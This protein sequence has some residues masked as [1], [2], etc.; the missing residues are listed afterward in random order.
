ME[1][2]G[3][4]RAFIKQ[5]TLAGA[6]MA[7]GLKGYTL[8]PQRIQRE[9]PAGK[10]IG[11]IGLDT[12]HGPAFARLL[13][14]ADAPAELGGFKI[15][16]ATPRGSKDIRSSTDMIP[17]NTEA[18]KAQGVVIVDSIKELLPLVDLVMLETNDGRLHLEQ[19]L[20]VFR[21][22]KTMFIDKPI[23]ASLKDTL[24][25]YRA[26]EKYR[27]P[28][29]SS[30]TLR[31]IPSVQEVAAGKIGTVIGADVFSPTPVEPTHPD[32]FWYGVHGVEML[33]TMLG[34]GCREVT[35]TYT[36]LSDMVVGVWDDQQI[37]T[38]RGLRNNSWSFGGYAY[39]EKGQRAALGDFT[40][41]APLVPAII[42]FF[43]TGK[44][45]VPEEQTIGAIAFMEAAEISKQKNGASIRI[46]SVMEL[47]EKASRKQSV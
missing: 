8:T 33:Y 21:A 30:S 20:P 3:S 9:A 13:N 45:P 32:L 15:V 34:A 46:S 11:V 22:G 44:S 26:A 37:G 6:G 36:P 25:I 17:R 35:R 39:G 43:K 18:I 1:H 27:V 31:Y 2:T 10:R 47:A 12:E 28:I 19:A 40:G 14:A 7:L 24:S 41:Y 29:F 4:R 16:A 42:D 23:A 5:A 38:L